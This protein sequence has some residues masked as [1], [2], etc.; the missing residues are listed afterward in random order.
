[1]EIR[2]EESRQYYIPDNFIEEGRVLQGRVKIRNL[3]EGIGMALISTSV[4]IILILAY[5][6]MKLEMKVSLIAVL[7]V[8]PLILGIS[9]FNGD[10]VSV[11][12]RSAFFWLKN[13]DTMLY[14]ATPRRLLIDPVMTVI[15]QTSAR[16]QI[17][18][19]IEEKRQ[20]K[21]RRKAELTLAEGKDY[22]FEKDEHVD[23]FM[24]RKR[25]SAAEIKGK[26][27]LEKEYLIDTSGNNQHM[28]K[29]YNPDQELE[30]EDED[31][32]L[33]KDLS[34]MQGRR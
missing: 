25:K 4:G 29:E 9:G 2:K 32:F 13:R 15:N 30:F 3:A 17:L 26:R 11:A 8:P 28:E 18:E 20:E 19:D 1:M 31:F 22:V 33:I 10:A 14:N 34:K 6:E 21:I 16:D 24:K 27:R 7:A 12:M 5:P 23:E